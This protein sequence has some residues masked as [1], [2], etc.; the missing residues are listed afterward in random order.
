MLISI[1]KLIVSIRQEFLV[2]VDKKFIRYACQGL[3]CIASSHPPL[4]AR[5]TR[6]TRFIVLPRQS[7]RARSLQQL[8]QG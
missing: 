5:D 4:V 1:Q 8:L 3:W 2:H 7:P 6:I